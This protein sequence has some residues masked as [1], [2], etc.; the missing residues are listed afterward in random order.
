MVIRVLYLLLRNA[1]TYPVLCIMDHQVLGVWT[2]PVLGTLGHPDISVVIR[3]LK[4]EPSGLYILYI[5]PLLN[6]LF[7]RVSGAINEAV[8]V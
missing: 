5:L 1:L 8:I 6:Y 2:D 3:S 7:L 4:F